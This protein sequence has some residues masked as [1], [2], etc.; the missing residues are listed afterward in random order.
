MCRWHLVGGYRAYKNIQYDKYLKPYEDVLTVYGYNR[1]PYKGYGG[2][3]PEDDEKVLYQNARVCPSLSEPHAEVICQQHGAKVRMAKDEEERNALYM[4]RRGALGAMTRLKPLIVVFDGTVPRN[5]PPK[6]LAEIEAISQ[7]YRLQ[8]G[9]LLQ[10][11]DGNVHPIIAYNERDSDE[12]QRVHD[13]CDVIMRLC[14]R[15]G[16]TITG[17]HGVGMEKLGAMSY[18]FS[19]DDP[20]GDG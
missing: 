10:A 14:V 12:S 20:Q 18:L 7:R 3:L 8:Y 15:L 13:G 11:G 16:G 9:T 1:W 19:L 5:R 2:L 17:E 6:A 4:G